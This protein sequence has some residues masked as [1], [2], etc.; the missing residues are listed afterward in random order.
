MSGYSREA[1]PQSSSSISFD[2]RSLSF[3][4][5]GPPQGGRGLDSC[6]RR[7]FV[8]YLFG[9]RQ[10]V[11][12]RQVI[13]DCGRKAQMRGRFVSRDVIQPAEIR[14][15]EIGAV[16]PCLAALISMA[17]VGP[18]AVFFAAGAPQIQQIRLSPRRQQITPS[19]RQLQPLF[20]RQPPG[21]CSVAHAVSFWARF[22]FILPREAGKDEI[23]SR[24]RGALSAPEL[25]GTVR[26]GAS[27]Q[28]KG[29]G[30]PKDA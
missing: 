7:A 3:Q 15:V 20:S 11:P 22:Y 2:S 1:K 21:V 10:A 5:K 8:E 29:G 6:F 25:Y 30:A 9:R 27:K 18:P 16:R 19:R 24:S 28:I 4:A 13:E 12:M 14:I 26:K 23:L 17:G